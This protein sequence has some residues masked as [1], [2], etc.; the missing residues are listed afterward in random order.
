MAIALTSSGM[1]KSRP[2]MAARQRNSLSKAS[3]PR[4]LAPTGPEAAPCRRD[5]LHHVSPDTRAYVDRLR[6][7]LHRDQRRAVDDLIELDLV[8]L[9]GDAARSTCHSSS[10]EG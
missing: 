9:A 4:G 8:V 6:R 3:D 10:R 7:L 5:Q 2:S 1:T